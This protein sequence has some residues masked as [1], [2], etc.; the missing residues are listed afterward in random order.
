MTCRP[1]DSA[2]ALHAG[3]LNGSLP[4]DDL[5]GRVDETAALI[6]AKPAYAIQTTKAA[7]NAVTASMVGTVGAWSDADALAAGLHDPEGQAA[8]AAYINRVRR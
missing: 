4:I 5:A 8:A 3:F 6:A 2:E 7:T 1:F